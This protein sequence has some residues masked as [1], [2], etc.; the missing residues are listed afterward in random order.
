MLGNH[1][2]G[3]G[4]I[5]TNHRLSISAVLQER[6]SKCSASVEIFRNSLRSLNIPL[7]ESQIADVLVLVLSRPPNQPGM[8]DDPS[9]RDW[10][11]DVVAE[12]LSQECRTLNLNWT[13]LVQHLDQPGLFIRSEVDFQILLRL[14]MRISSGV[15]F[16][17]AGFLGKVWMNRLS[18]LAFLIMA[19]GSHRSIVDFSPLVSPEQRLPGEVPTPQ[20]F[21]WLCI[22]LFTTL[23][24]LAAHGLQ[25]EVLDA[26][27]QA[28][29]MYP[30]YV[31]VCLAQVQDSSGVRAEI[32]RRVLPLFTGLPG[33]RPHSVSVMVKLQQVNPDLLVI[34]FRIAFKRSS[35]VQDVLDTDARLKSMGPALSRRVDEEGTVEDLL[36][37]WCIK[38]DRSNFNLEEV[39]NAILKRTP[40]IARTLVSFL[41]TNA[42]TLR[43]RAADGGLLSY[44]SFAELLR[45][46]QNY[47]NVVPVDELRLLAT[48]LTKQPGLQQNLQQIQHQQQQQQQQ[49]Q[50]QDFGQTSIL[51]LGVGG[52]GIPPI[53][54][55]GTIAESLH[56][57]LAGVGGQDG[58]PR[59]LNGGPESEEV[60]EEANAYF[61]KIYTS[62][63]SI[64]DVI[65]LLRRFKNSE[66]QREQEIFRCMIHNLF[67]E[68]R[69]FHKYPDKELQVTGKLFGTL[70]QHQLVSSITLGIALRYVLEALRKD[71][72]QGGSNEKM[73]RFGKIALERFRQRLGEWPQYCSHLV[74]IPHLARHCYDLFTD[75]QRAVNNPQP[76]Q[77]AAGGSAVGGNGGSGLPPGA[78]PGSAEMSVSGLAGLGIGLGLEGSKQSDAAAVASLSQYMGELTMSQGRVGQVAEGLPSATLKG[79]P[80]LMGGITGGG[81]GINPAIV[82]AFSSQ[83]SPLT[84]V[85]GS[86]TSSGSAPETTSSAQAQEE[87]SELSR[88]DRSH[89]IEKMAQINVDVNSTNMPTENIRDQI[90][91]IVNNIAKA[92]CEAKSIELRS[93]LQQEH[94]GWFAN[95]LVVKRISTQ[96]NLHSLYLTLLELLDSNELS[97]IVLDSAYHNVTKLLQSPNITTSSSERSLLRNLGIWL[98]QVT[99]AHNKPLLQRRINLKELLFW[100]YETGRLIAVCSFVAKIVEGTKESK[101][102]KPPNPWLMALLSVM[103]ELYEIEDLKMNIKF[104][105]Q[106]LCKN[107]NIKIEDIP[108]G[109]LLASCKM[110]IKDSRNPDFNV[111]LT[112]PVATPL[113]QPSPPT[114]SVPYPTTL[115]AALQQED[116]AAGAAAKRAVDLGIAAT[117]GGGSSAGV[118][119]H[120]Q[121]VIP[122]LATYVTISPTLQFFN[123]NPGHRRL[124]SLG[125]D[126]AIREIIQPVVERSVA[127]AS[128]TTK[129][130]VLKDYATEP[131]EQQLRTGAHLMISNLAGSLALATCKEPLRVSMGNQLRSL[132]T[133]VSSDQATV[134]QIVQ[135]C[136]N[137]NLDLGCML[138]EKASME[139]ATRDVDESLASAIQLRRK[140]RESGQPFTDTQTN[141]MNAKY[142]KELPEALKPRANGLQP[143]QLQV[144]EAFIKLRSAAAA[145][146]AAAIQ[147]QQQQQQQSQ[148]QDSGPEVV[149]QLASHTPIST[150]GTTLDMSQA[151]QAYQHILARIDM[152][153]KAV[154]VQA[155]GREVS[156]SMLGADH[157]IISLLRE[158]VILT[159]RISPNIRNETAM[160]FCE[161]VFKRT[162]ESVNVTDMLYLEV[163]VGILEAL[164]D[165]C[166]GPKKF[167]PEIVPWLSHYSVFNPNDE[168]SRKMHL[169]TLVL[170]LRAK[171][172]RSQDADVYFATYMDGGRNMIWVELALTFVRQCLAEGLAATYEFAHTFETVSKMRPT[173]AAV[174]KQL[175]KWLTDL[176]ALAAAKDEQ[177]I[178]TTPVT[179]AP[180]AVTPVAATPNASRDSSVREHVTAL[181][182]RWLSVWTSTNDQVFVQYL[183]L[184]HQY[185]VLKTEENADRFFRIATELC[186]EACL[187]SVQVS[188]LDGS[189]PAPPT[190][191]AALTYTVVD[192]LSKLFLLLVRLADKEGGDMTVRVNLLSRILNAIAR[193]ILDDHETKKVKQ[194]PFDQRPYFRLMSN[195]ANDLG[196][197]DPKQEASPS[198]ASLLTTYSQ[199]YLALE[200]S[201]VPGFAFA[202]LQLISH[203]SF[204]PHILLM[205]NQKGWPHMH[206]LVIALLL[207]LQPFLKQA[208][209]SD[210]TRRLYRGTLRMLLVLLHDFPEFLC[211]YHLSFSDAIPSTCIQLRNLI[212]SAYPRSM[213]L[214]DPFTPNLKVDTLPEI[215]QFPR[216]LTEYIPV[217]NSIKLRLDHYIATKQPS[218]FPLLL[219]NFLNS[220]PGSPYNMALTSLVIYVGNQAIVQ[221]QN[222]IP[223]PN[224]AAMEIFKYLVTTL[225]SEGRYHLFNIMANQLRYPNSHTHFFSC[226]LLFLFAEAETELLQEQI[227][228]V[229]LERLI[230]HRPHP[231]GLLITFIELI[232]N[233]RF[234]FWRK[235]F[236]R[237]APEI[238]RVFDS[239][240]RSCMGP[241]AASTIA[242]QQSGVTAVSA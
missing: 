45:A 240:A 221:L 136:C 234:A 130:L 154:Q 242:A 91:F 31:A 76:P 108:R 181:L 22:P 124:V 32:L 59:P 145:A 70:I 210:A 226:V 194:Q 186:V 88:Q 28:A 87:P 41:R 137:D 77:A 20:N 166:G 180:G 161:N 35:T 49:Q 214:P 187:K 165:S 241:N 199:V 228:R 25:M 30:E 164:C 116:E 82:A 131:N 78:L 132:F 98:G 219:T 8:T 122:N 223:L 118:N 177:K 140:M 92:N 85:L 160:T 157:E 189:T 96:P 63:I 38:A 178:A 53:P 175:Q 191:G 84:G 142:P 39:S 109:N 232:K 213:R 113:T 16:P 99:L 43:P 23:L 225:D 68:Y 52:G 5:G 46:L 79:S 71:P 196:V 106:V 201:R 173:N 36:G 188:S 133:Q 179:P 105:V 233:P 56:Q 147:Q 158:M 171:L 94:Y 119:L 197:P 6:G 117:G 190:P 107:I 192:A 193:T 183:Q 144:Y 73:F 60:E 9:K 29:T 21:S 27:S 211:D 239:M 169:T 40:Q 67:D 123:A 230:V 200:P 237:C 97:N 229:L 103:R 231:W 126:R 86:T 135:I 14:F 218:E 19:A 134:E 176:R 150:P 112:A 151:L 10:N 13:A 203:R 75:A 217:L 209:L 220:T 89:V 206:R 170:L 121:T 215:S 17:V 54:S 69:F 62:D 11:L 129:Q 167:V 172:L 104:E 110:P 224:S 153:L 50:L 95:Y 1:G 24:E 207:F 64:S 146:A 143:Q 155:Q 61:Q 185:Q 47:P 141:S 72:D 101:I 65:Q 168:V 55:D 149:S 66:R 12:V 58:L 208:Q 216:I 125:V 198:I 48:F 100:G 174:R 152:S 138:I 212:L 222:K 7:D 83:T 37:Y 114:G 204:M 128:I 236:V 51:G 80:L 195:L 227:T 182:E 57:Q 120:E 4:G 139:K 111:K 44:E 33:S 42:E 163:M 127:I 159:Q 202:W 18:Q 156:I 162:V 184:M 238:E 93:L 81:L 74:Q 90:S 102:F 3:G 205:K 2:G 34:L 148:Q 115:S 26:I 15:Q 235:S